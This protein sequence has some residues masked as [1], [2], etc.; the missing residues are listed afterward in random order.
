MGC[1]VSN[2]DSQ[3]EDQK[4]GTNG[5][6]FLKSQAEDYSNS[7]NFSTKDVQG[8]PLDVDRKDVTD[9]DDKEVIEDVESVS[10]NNNHNITV[11]I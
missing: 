11:K 3:K 5:S 2:V 6:E 10:V 9:L 1:V 4:N 8:I 7:N